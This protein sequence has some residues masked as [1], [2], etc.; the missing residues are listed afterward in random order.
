MARIS[1]EKDRALAKQDLLRVSV[2]ADLLGVAPK[3]INIWLKDE[4]SYTVGGVKYLSWAL[5]RHKRANDVAF[6]S[7]PADGTD[8]HSIWEKYSSV[9]TAITKA[10]TA[11]HTAPAGT[12]A[13]VAHAV[14]ALAKAKSL[15]PAVKSQ[16]LPKVENFQSAENSEAQIVLEVPPLPDENVLT[17][18]EEFLRKDKQHAK[19]GVVVGLCQSCSH[20]LEIYHSV[21]G[22]FFA[23]G[24][25]AS[26]SCKIGA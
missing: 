17:V 7:L 25:V 9:K 10:I 24:T 21:I 3:T 8:A 5:V 6:L 13:A 12:I 1:K 20:S 2:V 11:G 26:C 15:L 19:Q 14:T 16:E 18:P 22:C 4:G 23:K